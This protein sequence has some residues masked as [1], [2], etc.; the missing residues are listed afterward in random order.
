MPAKVSRK[1][2]QVGDSK[3]SVLP[4]DWLRAFGLNVGDTIEVFYDFIVLIKP[5]GVP[6][7]L[8][9]LKKELDILAR[10]EEASQ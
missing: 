10:L 1:I 9:F 4:P 5:L 7:D 6:L 8:D 3:G 2:L